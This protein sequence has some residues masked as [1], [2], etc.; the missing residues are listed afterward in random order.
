MIVFSFRGLWSRQKG[1]LRLRMLV[2]LLVCLLGLQIVTE[3]SMAVDFIAA[4][5]KAG[6]FA[7]ASGQASFC[8]WSGDS[9]ATIAG[10]RQQEL[11]RLASVSK[12]F[13]SYLALSSLGPNYRFE[14]QIILTD[15]SPETTPGTYDVRIVGGKDPYFAY[16]KVFF[17][18]SELNR[19]GVKKIRNLSFDD[20]LRIFLGF[21]D[22]MQAVWSEQLLYN[23]AKHRDYVFAPVL[24]EDT[25]ENLQLVLNTQRWSEAMKS[26]YRRIRTRAA[27]YKI[28]LTAIPSLSV[29]RIGRIP[30][31]KGYPSEKEQTASEQKVVLQSL[32]LF[33]YL[34]DMNKY[35][36][37]FIA[38]QLFLVVGGIPRLQRLLIETV[39][40]D[41]S[42]FKFYTGSGLPDRRE[43]RKDNVS[44]CSA[45]VQ[46][47][48]SFSNFLRSAPTVMSEEGG[49]PKPTRLTLRDMMLVAGYDADGT[50]APSDINQIQDGA[51][52]VKTGSLTEVPAYNL[53]GLVSSEN[54]FRWFG[55]FLN[56][57]WPAFRQS[58]VTQI[59][60][61]NQGAKA[62]VNSGTTL[63]DEFLSFDESSRLQA[64][65][66]ALQQ[67]NVWEL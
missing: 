48:N 53:A 37:N 58:I 63:F 21:R 56:D 30:L 11:I 62:L 7:K 41:E 28:D 19:L 2:R 10:Y 5:K 13:V 35:S 38:D 50:Y 23:P 22:T 55:L 3:K 44:T 15:V 59:I 20:G 32:P 60:R 34:K 4:M 6:V 66:F 17:L 25:R 42:D 9:R 52:V 12:L 43:G 49:V 64:R 33:R 40:I 46:T 36:I 45:V 27:E 57:K 47:I 29:E 31:G 65:G 26:R 39:G 54:G 16:D 51:V 1:P 14:T 8:A 61:E 24:W 18:V 67:E